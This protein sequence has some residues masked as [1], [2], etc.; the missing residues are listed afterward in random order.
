MLRYPFLLML[1][2]GVRPFRVFLDNDFIPAG[3][4]REMD[5]DGLPE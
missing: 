5:A 1:L 2:H 3:F 4:F